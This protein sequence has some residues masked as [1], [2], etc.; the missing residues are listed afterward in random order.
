MGDMR[1]IKLLVSIVERGMG[2][3]VVGIYRK[4]NVVINLIC[5]GKGTA[6]SEILDYLGLNKNEKDI[7]LSIIPSCKS[8]LILESLNNSI[9]LINHG[10]GI[11]F[12]V[13]I[14]S[15]GV[16]ISKEVFLPTNDCWNKENKKDSDNMS[17][18]KEFGVIVAIVNYGFSEQT[19]EFAKKAGAT[20]GT[21]IHCRS[22][23]TNEVSKFLGITIEPEKEFVLILAENKNRYEIMKMINEKVGLKT[24][25]RGICLSL[26]VDDVVGVI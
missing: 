15:A 2:E 21:V 24:E 11:A 13:P 14:S 16:I 25:A 5:L 7:I 9:N 8:K 12:S 17:T 3:K 20:G 1:K 10:N 18:T 4:H 23:D 26:P 22:L 19:M 6:S